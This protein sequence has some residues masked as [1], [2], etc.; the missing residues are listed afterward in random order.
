[1]GSEK[2]CPVGAMCKPH[3]WAIIFQSV[4]KLWVLSSV[5]QAAKY[6][7]MSPNTDNTIFICPL[8]H[9]ATSPGDCLFPYKVRIQPPICIK[10]WDIFFRVYIFKSCFYAFL[11]TLLHPHVSLTPQHTVDFKIKID[12]FWFLAP[13]FLNL[14]IWSTMCL[15]PIHYCVQVLEPRSI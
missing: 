14:A 1:M 15:E 3:S 7:H 13:V 12:Y 5:L 9:K 4:K 8:L 2:P 6:K 10:M 11:S